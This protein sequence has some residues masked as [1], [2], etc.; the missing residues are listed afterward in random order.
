[1]NTIVSLHLHNPSIMILITSGRTGFE[2]PLRGYKKHHIQKINLKTKIKDCHNNT[3]IGGGN[4]F[5][6]KQ[7]RF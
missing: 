2:G 5:G 4:I 3:K 1:M 6:G 7:L